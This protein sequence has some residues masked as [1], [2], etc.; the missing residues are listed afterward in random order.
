MDIPHPIKSYTSVDEFKVLE[1]NPPDEGEEESAEWLPDFM[2]P[3]HLTKKRRGRAPKAKKPKAPKAPKKRTKAEK[4]HFIV[5][6]V[7]NEPQIAERIEDALPAVDQVAQLNPD[8][9]EYANA[10]A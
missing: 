1:G 6:A 7:V 3:P 4:T 2:G 10:N 9:L 5:N 8:Q